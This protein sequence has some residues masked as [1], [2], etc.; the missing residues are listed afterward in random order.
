MLRIVTDKAAVER[1]L[2]VTD[3]DNGTVEIK[4][5]DGKEY[6]SIEIGGGDLFALRSFLLGV[7]C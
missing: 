5:V 2:H 7:E 4:V 6:L 1:E 3:Q